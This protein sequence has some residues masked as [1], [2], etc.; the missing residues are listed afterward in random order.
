MNFKTIIKM[1]KLKSF[2]IILCTLFPTMGFAQKDANAKKILDNT[3]AIFNTSKGIR[4]TFNIKNFQRGKLVGRSDGTILLKGNKFQVNTPE[5]V[6][7]FNGKTQWTY[8]AHND[9]VNV[10]N[11]SNEELQNINPYVFLNLYKQGYNYRLGKIAKW[12]GKGVYEVILTA[13]NTKENLSV[14]TIY[15][16]KTD[17]KPLQIILSTRNDNS[18]Q[19]SI[20]SFNKNQ[21]LTENIFTFNKKKYPKAEII[22]LR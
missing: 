2:I 20:D 13:E 17:Y 16:A 11:P 1:L 8:I 14:I 7:W 19:I 5:M 9:E 6:C 15:I 12:Q 3:A 21:N 22:D 4:A 10:A 18:S